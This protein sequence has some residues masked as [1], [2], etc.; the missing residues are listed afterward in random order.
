MTRFVIYVKIFP[1]FL[2]ECTFLRAATSVGNI[3][4]RSAQEVWQKTYNIDCERCNAPS[5]FRLLPY[6]SIIAHLNA[7]KQKIRKIQYYPIGAFRAY[8]KYEK[9]IFAPAR[10]LYS[11]ITRPLVRA[12]IVCRKSLQRNVQCIEFQL[13]N[14]LHTSFYLPQ[15]KTLPFIIEIRIVL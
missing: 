13:L 7:P 8:R 15:C 4:F 6:I 12:K 9:H 3:I 1:T 10:I 5:A 14:M 11:T 2:N